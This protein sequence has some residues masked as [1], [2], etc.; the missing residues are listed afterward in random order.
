MSSSKKTV[1]SNVTGVA[2]AE[3]SEIKVLPGSPVWYD[4][5]VNSYSDFGGEVSAVMADPINASRQNQRGT[6]TDL[7]ASGGYNIDMT[8]GLTRDM[9]GFFFADAH[10][11][12][13]TNPLNGAAVTIT[14]VDGAGVFS[15]ASGLSVFTVGSLVLASGF[16][17]PTNNAAGKVTASASGSVTTDIATTAEGSPPSTAALKQVGY[18][19]GSGD[20]SMTVGAATVTLSSTAGD[21]LNLDLQVGE[22]VFIG[23]D[24]AGTRYDAGYGYGRVQSKDNDDVVLDNVAWTGGTLTTESGAGK[25]IRVYAG[26][27]IRNEKSPSLIKCRTYQVERTLG[28]DDDGVQSEY[29]TGAVKNELTLNIPLSDKHTADFGYVALDNEQRTGLEGVKSGTHVSL[30]KQKLYNT[31]SSVFRLQMAILDAATLSPTALFGYAS[32]ATFTI[33][34][35]A[36]ATKAIGSLGGI[37][38]TVGNF[39]VGGNVTAYFTD[40][41]AV[42]AVRN[43]ADVGFNAILAQ[44]NAGLVYDVPLLGV[45]GGRLNVEKDNPITVPIEQMGAENPYGYTMS[46]TSFAYLPTVAMPV[47]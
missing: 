25:T 47:V 10:E 23:G 13:D 35:N 8:N 28:E 43:N 33:T 34:N 22:W 37:D 4:R 30:P 16:T 2:V 29:L 14:G 15:A 9:Q 1:N 21:W 36:T 24:A 26:T 5:G 20:L 31:S 11:K 38:I 19:F 12:V 40:V 46:Y 7:D 41:A 6:V 3:E 18:E 27:F 39:V 44:G 42:K 45:S 17:T 32:D